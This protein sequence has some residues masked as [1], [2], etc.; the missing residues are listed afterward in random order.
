MCKFR[1]DFLLQYVA[2]TVFLFSILLESTVWSV[3][4]DGDILLKISKMFRYL[5]Y[6][7]CLSKIVMGRYRVRTLWWCCVLATIFF[8]SYVGSRNRVM[9]LY[10]LILFAAIGVDSRCHIRI[11]NVMQTSFLCIFILLSLTGLVTDYV[12]DPNSRM[13][14]GLGFTWT[15]TAPIIYFYTM[16]CYIYIKREKISY[17]GYLIMECVNFWLYKMTDT[18]M[19]F[20]FS[21]FFLLF[22][23]I[24]RSM[25]N[26]WRFWRLFERLYCIVPSI[27]CT[28]SLIL[29]WCYDSSNDVWRKLNELLS[30]RLY[31]GK[32]AI[33]N[34]GIHVFGQN[35]RWVGFSIRRPTMA[36]AVGYN[37]VDCS[38]LQLLL[39]Y[40]VLFLIAVI[41]IYT[42][43]IYRAV[44]VQDYYLV[45][46]LL[47]VLLFGITEPRLMNFTFNPF[48]LM[49]FC[50]LSPPS[51]KKETCLPV[52][53]ISGHAEAKII[54]N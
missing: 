24:E 1:K 6:G 43:A 51:G 40:G 32:E 48:P 12:F 14:H 33:L 2:W 39:E 9:V 28:A 38:Y 13:R 21:S 15:T 46:I 18:R 42:V 37:Y 34:Y 11:A 27:I 5:A 29:Y 7:I 52:E 23:A 8:L 20:V 54:G 49:A 10:L 16:L 4:D 30:N 26:R 44:K 17:L 41:G 3:G 45:W 53:R 22:F 25:K 47:I 19:A 50:R 35:I 31:L 36:E